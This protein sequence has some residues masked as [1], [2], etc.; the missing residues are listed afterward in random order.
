[1]GKTAAPVYL[2]IGTE[3]HL[4]IRYLFAAQTFGSS[5]Q[6]PVMQH[7]LD[8]EVWAQQHHKISVEAV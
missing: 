5:N 7:A 3:L 6:I 2:M 4:K 8:L 1:M